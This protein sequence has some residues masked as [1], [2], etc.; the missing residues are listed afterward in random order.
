MIRN[1]VFIIIAVLLLQSCGTANKTA[2]TQTEV[3]E[4]QGLL[5]FRDNYVNALPTF[6]YLQI[7]SR[8]NADIKGK[9]HSAT[10]RLYFEKDSMI[11]ANAS[12][13][14]ITGARAKITPDQVEAYEVIDRT[15]IRDNFDYIN[16]KLKVDFIDFQKFQQ[17][18]LG[19]LFLIEP[20]SAYRLETTKDNHYALIYKEND[21]LRNKPQDQKY[22]HTFYLD[23]DYRLNKVDVLDSKSNT[24]ITIDYT[25]W[26]LIGDKQ[27]PGAVKILVKG[28]DTDIITLDYNNFEF[29]QMNPPFRIPENYKERTLN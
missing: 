16:Q 4:D 26:Q 1:I 3:V 5:T 2:K 29:S 9:S 18:L 17:L 25:N 13:L 11:W 6:N 23:G 14:G 20:W 12:M 19:Q 7:K 8:I 27:I 15:F 22:I 10:L 21:A 24:H 28:K